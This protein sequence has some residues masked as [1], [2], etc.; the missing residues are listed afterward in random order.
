[1]KRVKIEYGRIPLIM[2]V[3]IGICYAVA[4][5]NFVFTGDDLSYLTRWNEAVD[6]QGWLSWP[7]F[8]IT[9][10]LDTNGRM[11]NMLTPLFLSF[12]P[13]LLT[14]I[15]MGVF[16][17]LLLWNVLKIVG[18]IQAKRQSLKGDVS[19]FL[20]VVLLALL[21]FTLPWWDSLLLYDCWLNYPVALCIGLMVVNL[22]RG[23]ERNLLMTVF[24]CFFSFIAGAMHEACGIALS[25]GL[26]AYYVISNRRSDKKKKWIA[27][28]YITG[29]IFVLLSPGIW[30]RFGTSNAEVGIFEVLIT[31]DFYLLLL[32]LI[33]SVSLLTEGGRRR[34]S[35]MVGSRW[36]I[37]V[38]AATVS[39][40]FSAV[41]GIIGRTGF[42][43]QVFS[44]IAIFMYFSHFSLSQRKKNVRGIT[45]F[46]CLLVMIHSVGFAVYQRR[47]GREL[48]DAVKSYS[49]SA[50]GLVFMDYMR[51]EDVPWWLLN[52]VRG[53][54][55]D[56]DLWIK[57]T[58]EQ[59]YHSDSL[60]FVILPKMIK[61]IDMNSVKSSMK[62]GRYIIT[63][64]CPE[65]SVKVKTFENLDLILSA[66]SCV[67]KECDM[68]GDEDDSCK[69]YVVTPFSKDG[70]SMY[71]LSPLYVDPGDK[72]K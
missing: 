29:S 60:K 67:D 33:I 31:S 66:D 18:L 51:D 45:L 20:S 69:K 12:L 23:R 65:N 16:M 63:P 43:S 4:L 42:F 5:N 53:V 2:I 48:S 41:S 62:F 30:K 19:I 37:F 50:D 34:L 13:K 26:I 46:I 9:H 44:L 72:Y 28:S 54:P 3:I 17:S 15:F 10:W 52:K 49:A 64:H 24:I 25:A 21:M 61:N 56:D 68:S 8:C 71:L 58:I 36:I 7:Y 27:T 32:L 22:L 6:K 39:G 47:A 59:F 14:D 70:C 40:C 11:A 35:Q 1:M 55:D 38:V 57:H